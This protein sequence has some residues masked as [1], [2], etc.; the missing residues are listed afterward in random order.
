MNILFIT[1]ELDKKNGWA[2]VGVELV[3]EMRQ[4]HDVTIISRIGD[5]NN[6]GHNLISSVDY[7]NLLKLFVDIFQITRKLQAKKIDTIICNIEL[8]LPLAVMLKKRLGVPKLILIGHGTYIYFPFMQGL[9]KFL[10]LWLARHV[11]I[12]VVPSRYTYNK[13][14][15]WWKG[16]LEIINWGVNTDDYY[17]V[18]E[19]QKERAFIC[20]GSLKNRK[21]VDTLFRAFAEL[22]R[23]HHDVKL[24]L[25]GSSSKKLLRFGKELGILENITFTGKISHAELL[26]YYSSSL[27]HIL[28]SVNTP[29]AFEGYGLVHLE[30]NA[31]CIP[32]IGAADSANEDIIID[33][34]NGYLCTQRDY[35]KLVTLMERIL[36]GGSRYD[37]LCENALRLA[38]SRSWHNTADRLLALAS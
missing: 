2:T 10:N 21:G 37:R 15:A 13:V 3:G 4:N 27:C 8:Y 32:S 25:T 23:T 20:V 19:V 31:C 16:N 30:A 12:I 5:R 22:L 18:K 11:D 29:T 28:V 7:N 36:E 9:R 26:K 24:Y 17:A 35:K 14:R 34:Y 6:A 33:G 1:N 38:K